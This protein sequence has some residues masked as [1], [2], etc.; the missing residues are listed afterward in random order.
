MPAL[1]ITLLALAASSAPPHA[2]DLAIATVEVQIVS[3][4]T[5]NLRVTPVASSI[6]GAQINTK[7]ALIEFY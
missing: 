6:V 1:L 7:A 5:L 4:Q 3:G 2:H